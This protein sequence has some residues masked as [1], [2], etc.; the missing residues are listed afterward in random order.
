MSRQVA[1]LAALLVAAGF[2]AGLTR[3][4]FPLAEAQV[5]ESERMLEQGLASLLAGD[6]LDGRS[7]L[8]RVSYG[9][10]SFM[11][12]LDNL[13]TI[14]ALIVGPQAAL[15]RVAEL[16]ER[17]PQDNELRLRLGELHYGSAAFEEAAR[18]AAEV[19]RVAPSD[20][21]ARYALA[22]YQLA[23]GALVE[24][25][26]S[27]QS[28]LQADPGAH[29]ARVALDALWRHAARYPEQSQTHFA[30]AFFCSLQGQTAQEI[31]ELERYLAARPSGAI[32]DAARARLQTLLESDRAAR[33]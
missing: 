4:A 5:S 11:T 9:S 32:A 17:H 21:R 6:L 12:A 3:E 19:A 28:A 1:L 13:A 10:A 31:V 20:S 26:S 18:Q 2:L 14:D 8:E 22:L 7:E 29:Q 27:Y 33:R 30:L 25:I 23:G 24:A 15:A 16:V